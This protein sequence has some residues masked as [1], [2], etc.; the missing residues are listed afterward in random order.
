LESVY[1][2]ADIKKTITVG[3]ALRGRQ[4]FVAA[5]IWIIGAWLQFIGGHVALA[6][7]PYR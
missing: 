7:V 5:L 4:S 2:D 6:A 3:K 1:P